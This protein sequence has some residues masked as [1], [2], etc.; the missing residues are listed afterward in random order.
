MKYSDFQV[1]FKEKQYLQFLERCGSRK[2]V[3][4]FEK[5][6]IYPR[7]FESGEV[8]KDNLIW[9]SI[10]DHIKAHLYLVQDFEEF[11]DDVDYA[12][13]LKAVNIT[14]NT[15]W[16]SLSESERG[17]IEQSIPQIAELRQKAMQTFI[18]EKLEKQRKQ[19]ISPNWG[20]T[21]L[22][23][24]EK[25]S[26]TSEERFGRKAGYFF[27][28]EA[29]KHSKESRLRKYGSLVGM[30]HTEEAR[31]KAK[32][33]LQD[34]Y[35][36]STNFLRPEV[37]AKARDT[38]KK[39]YGGNTGYMNQPGIKAKSKRTHEKLYGG[40]TVLMNTPEARKKAAESRKKTIQMRLAV[41]K[42]S[43]FQNWY[44][45]QSKVW[46]S[47]TYAVKPFLK[48]IGKT[49]EQVAVL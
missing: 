34:R 44:K 17:D 10:E 49:L 14:C 2:P 27:T 42:T 11:R 16:Q 36:V 32:N 47:P 41:V 20:C 7:S 5:H 26:K 12:K 24:R 3:K 21:T 48:E 8:G 15:R 37:R 35:G 13:A 1:K 33:T 25:A 30:M 45:K 38:M 29:L 22:E 28:E 43:E 40:M 18:R 39:L 9:L 31:E 46:R 6:H 23:A 4:G 19:G